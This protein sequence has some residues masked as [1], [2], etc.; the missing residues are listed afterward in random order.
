LTGTFSDASGVSTASDPKEESMRVLVVL[1]AVVAALAVAPLASSGGWATVGFEPLPDGMSAGGTWKPTIFVKQHGV[2]PLSGL[3]PVVEI[4]DDTGAVERFNA[5]ETSDAGVY[6]ASVVFPSEGD[7]RVTINSGFGDSHV[8]YGPVAI[9]PG[10]GD[11][12][13][14]ELPVFGLGVA[15]LA[16]VGG[17][18]LLAARRP[19]RLTP[20]SG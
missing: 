12:G 13:S 1:G 20:A 19:R 5:T 6:E 14:R 17:L 18:A 4:Y 3:Q 15:L 9:G 8:S 7:W 11:G 16:L 10:A 2:T